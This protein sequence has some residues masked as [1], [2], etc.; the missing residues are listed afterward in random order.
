MI[1]LPMKRK[2]YDFLLHGTFVLMC[3][4][5]TRALLLVR[6]PQSA[7]YE[8]Y[9]LNKHIYMAILEEGGQKVA[10]DEPEEYKDEFF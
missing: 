6:S 4:R 10:A 5:S 8:I 9:F 3:L 2:S 7:Y 1:L